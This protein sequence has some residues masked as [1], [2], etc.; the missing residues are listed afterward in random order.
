[1]VHFNVKKN[2]CAIGIEN[3]NIYIFKYPI[4]KSTKYY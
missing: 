4:M 1:M 3:M 2:N